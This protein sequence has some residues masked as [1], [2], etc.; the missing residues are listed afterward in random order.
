MSKQNNFRR[1]NPLI[2]EWV[3]VAVNRINRPWQGAKT[4]KSTTI[5]T[6][7]NTEQSILNPLAPGGTRSSGI[8][9]EN[10][11]STYVFDNDFPSFTE[12][13]ECA[14][15]DEND[16]LFKQHEVKGVCK[17]I[18]Y[19]PNSQLTL[20]TMDVKEVR[21]V[22]DIWNQQYLELGPKYEWVQ[23][24]ENRGAVVGCSNMH[25]HG[26]L[27]ASNYLPTL[28]MKKHESQKKHFEKHGKVMLMDYLE[29]ETLKKE[30][31]IMRNEHWTWLVPYWAF[32]PYETML[33]PNRHVERF[34][35]LG[36]VE[37]QSLSEILRSL[38]IKYDNVFECSFPYMMGWSGAP[39]GSFLTE[40]C[41][42]WQ[43]HLSFFPPLLRSATVPKFL[44]G[45][46]VFAEKQRDLSPEIAAKTLSE[47]DEE[48]YSKKLQ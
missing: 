9:N 7:S 28:P 20:A 43:L 27:W 15:K 39:T 24:F 19:H 30:R 17:V 25:P 1:Y 4:E 34:T 5:S 40:N 14:G 41:S 36:E 42:F 10:Y 3:I 31:I 18:C 23:I 12:F 22:I 47:I 16:D 46:E 48:H 29:Q 21:V 45:Y 35:D 44:A 38:L 11:V 32:W 13:E 33:L 2:D 6:S 8:A 37:K 26:Q